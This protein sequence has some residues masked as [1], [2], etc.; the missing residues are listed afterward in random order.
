MVQN[1]ITCFMIINVFVHALF[2][3]KIY[4]I[5]K[6]KKVSLIKELYFVVWS[7]WNK[8]NLYIK[9]LIVQMKRCWTLWEY[10]YFSIMIL[11]EQDEVLFFLVNCLDF[12][13]ITFHDWFYYLSMRYKA[14]EIEENR[15]LRIHPM[16]KMNVRV[17]QS[18]FCS[19]RA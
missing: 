15:Y 14:N 13:V 3:T 18:I 2:F 9:W 4:T 12:S 5:F 16:E 8:C 1:V 7:L 6:A 10:F 11:W 19:R 17:L